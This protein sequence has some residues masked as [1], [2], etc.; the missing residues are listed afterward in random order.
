[1]AATY[2]EKA[3]VLRAYDLGEADRIVTLFTEGRGP[4]RA[5]AKGI[6]RTGSKFGARLEPFTLLDVILHEGRNLDTIVQTEIINAHAPIRA[7][8]GKYLFG[9]AMLE[10]IEKS[11]R[12]NQTIP[13]L[14]PALCVT[15]DVLEGEVADPS[16][17]L[18][19]F[20]LK[21]CALIGYH[22]H[23]AQCLNGGRET[24][25]EKVW[26]NLIGGGVVCV[27]CRAG[28]DDLIPLAP[29][30][31]VLMNQLM[32]LDMAAISSS[33]VS[34]A[35]AVEILSIAFRFSEA[36]LERPLR[37]RAVVLNYLEKGAL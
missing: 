5:V 11:L 1:M 34:P 6:K 32:A 36:F 3:I 18:A 25:G 26:L 30:A 12:E 37:S 16:L 10:M 28:L 9:E 24:A 7:D 33:R 27:N 23:L 2:K 22:P 14:F 21:V 17:L 35:L 15:L 29:A 31:L 13:R 4:V 8:Y 20:D 19:A